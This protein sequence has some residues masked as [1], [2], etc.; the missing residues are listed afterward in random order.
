MAPLE[1]LLVALHAASDR[2]TCGTVISSGIGISLL[3]VVYFLG[4]LFGQQHRVYVG[5]NTAL[6]DGH[7]V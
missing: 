4:E 5:E 3:F 7:V 6:C 2:S 1:L